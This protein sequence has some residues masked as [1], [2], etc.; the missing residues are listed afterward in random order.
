MNLREGY[1]YGKGDTKIFYRKDVPCGAKAI[2]VI[3]HGYMEHSGRYV[4]FAESLVKENIGV[5]LIDHRGN[6]RSE[7]VEGDVEDFFDFIEDMHL[8][9]QTLKRY[10]KPVITY[11]HS[12]GGLI[13]FIYGLKYQDTISGQIFS[14]PAL[15]VPLGCKNFPPSFYEGIGNV[16]GKMR[17]YRGGTELA[18][19]NEFYVEAFKHDVDAN[20]SATLRFMDQFL[21]VGVEYA[22]THAGDYN[23]PSLFLLGEKDHVIPISRNYEMLEKITCETKQVIE[24]KGCMHDLLHDLDEEVAKIKKDILVWIEAHLKNLNILEGKGI[25][26]E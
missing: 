20:E 23:L 3:A 7:G 11:G 6:G 15:G 12:M 2:V 8:L 9:I 1:F 26:I 4:A 17:V 10:G 24:Y 13:T 18:T 19:R 25:R 22:N 16:A 5:C 14:S 21:R